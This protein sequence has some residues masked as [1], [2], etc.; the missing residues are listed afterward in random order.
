MAKKH[1][2]ISQPKEV[3]FKMPFSHHGGHEVTFK[4]HINLPI[5]RSDKKV[6]R[7]KFGTYFQ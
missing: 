4:Q 6:L 5:K 7:Q 3:L 2:L 1:I